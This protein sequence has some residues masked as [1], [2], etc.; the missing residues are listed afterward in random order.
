MENPFLWTSNGYGQVCSKIL[1][2]AARIGICHRLFFF[3]GGGG[4]NEP[5][6]PE[7]ISKVLKKL[8]LIKI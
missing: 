5:P 8:P 4:G 7:L 1:K 3:F 2:V 6:P